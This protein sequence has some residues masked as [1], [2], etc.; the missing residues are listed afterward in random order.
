MG[1]CLQVD[2]DGFIFTGADVGATDGWTCRTSPTAKVPGSIKR[3]ATAV[4][5][6]AMVVRLIHERLASPLASR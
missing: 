4:G 3:V 1:R 5:E 6:G 2:E